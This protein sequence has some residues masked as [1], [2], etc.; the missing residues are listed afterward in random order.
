VTEVV[1][2]TVPVFTVNVANIAPG[3]T[4]T[5]AGTLA[6]VEFELESDTTAP[7]EGAAAVSSTVPV[8]DSPF[9]ILHGFTPTLFSVAAGGSIV[10]LA[11]LL[12]PE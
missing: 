4:V 3:A 8:A 9:T 6:S 11:V 1:E 10:T 12:A 2:L 7:P 5:L